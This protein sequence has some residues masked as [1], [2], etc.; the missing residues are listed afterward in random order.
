MNTTTFTNARNTEERLTVYM[1]E[2]APLNI[3]PSEWKEAARA[4]EMIDRSEYLLCVREYQDGRALVYGEHYAPEKG[5][6]KF[7]PVSR[8]GYL[9]KA[10]ERHLIP[11][12]IR[13]VAGVLKN[14]RLGA[15]CIEALPPEEI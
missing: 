13:R 2:R 8:A 12:T 14:E 5:T 1:S 10:D 15:K 7:M 9:L 4:T 3:L 11:R 6:T